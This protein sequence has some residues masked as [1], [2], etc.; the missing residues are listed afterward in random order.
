MKTSEIKVTVKLKDVLN[1]PLMSAWERM[2]E[3]Y[4]INEWC[5][6]EGLADDDITVEISLEDA[7]LYGLVERD[8]YNKE[9]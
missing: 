8:T 3:K 5:L 9:K 4:G 6:N 7:E 2:C 1:A